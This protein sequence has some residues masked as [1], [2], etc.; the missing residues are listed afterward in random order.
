MTEELRWQIRVHLDDG[1]EVASVAG[2]M[3]VRDRSET[4]KMLSGLFSGAGMGGYLKFD[5]SED[6]EFVVIPLARI[7]YVELHHR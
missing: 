6:G 1:A 4:R 3:S 5:T 7:R 2:P